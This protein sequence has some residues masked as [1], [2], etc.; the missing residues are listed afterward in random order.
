MINPFFCKAFDTV[1][2]K[3]FADRSCQPGEGEAIGTGYER[4]EW[5]TENNPHGGDH[6]KWF[7]QVC[8]Y[9]VVTKHRKHVVKVVSQMALFLGG[10]KKNKAKQKQKT[11][12]TEKE[13]NECNQT[14]L[15]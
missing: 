8:I 7:L 12:N 1:L 4:R 3:S 2:K 14:K 15:L 6:G 13:F 11:K 5:K 10:K 9:F